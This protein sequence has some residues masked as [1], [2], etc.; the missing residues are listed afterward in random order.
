[1]KSSELEDFFSG[2]KNWNKFVDVFNAEWE[3]CPFKKQLITALDGHEDIAKV[4]YSSIEEKALEWINESVP[5]LGNMSPRECLVSEGTVKR[6]K[7]ML[8]RM[9]R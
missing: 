1:M 7:E 2:E 3:K 5:A 4:V 6:L 8:M 9:P